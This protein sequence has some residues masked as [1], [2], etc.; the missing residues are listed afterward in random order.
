MHEK[1]FKVLVYNLIDGVWNV[2][3]GHESLVPFGVWSYPKLVLRNQL[4]V[5]TQ[6]WAVFAELFRNYLAVDRLTSGDSVFF[7]RLTGISVKP[8]AVLQK[9]SR[10]PRTK[11]VA[12]FRWPREQLYLYKLQTRRLKSRSTC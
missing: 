9:G 3:V 12:V 2:R 1:V 7:R 4:A 6:S 5:I 8:V 11:L 10:T